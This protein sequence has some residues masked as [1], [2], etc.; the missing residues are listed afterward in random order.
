MNTLSHK[1]VSIAL[2][3]T[4]LVSLSGAILPAVA[5]AQSTSDLQAQ[6]AALLAQI[7]QLQ[8]QLNAQQGGGASSSYNYTRDLTVGSK[9]DDVTALQNLLASKGYF[10]VAATG[11]F[12]PIT[13]AAVAAWQAASGISPAAGYFGPKSRAAVAAMAGPAAPAAPGAPVGVPAPNA[14]A[15]GLVVSLASDNPAPGSLIPSSSRNKVLNVTFTAGV[16]GP[17]TVSEVKFK[18]VGVLSDSSVSGAYLTEAGKVLAQYNSISGGVLNF[19]GLSLAVPAG[20]SRTFGLQI[21]PAAG[22]SAGNTVSFSIESAADVTSWDASNVAVNESGSFPVKGNIFTVTTVSN[23]SLATLTVASSSIGTNVTAGTNNNLIAAWSFTGANSRINLSSLNFKVIGSA[24]K[25]DIKNVKLMVNG[26]QI[27]KT[28]DSVG[29]NGEAF[30]DAS[31]KP[32]VLNTGSNNVQVYADIMGSPS[33]TFQFE[34]LNSYDVFALDSQYN[35]PVLGASNVG[36]QVTIKSGT[37]TMS[38]ATNTPT[39][40]I[41]AGQSS[42]TIAKFTVYAGGEAVKIKWLGVGLNLVS[43]SGTIDRLF[44]NL[45]LVDD[46][47]GQ[48]GTTIN[49]LSTSVTCTDTDFQNST[50]SYRNCFGNSSSPINYTIPANT[51]RVLSLVVDVQS[52]ASFTTVTGITVANTNNLQGLT[53]SATA[54]SAAVNGSALTLS[55]SNLTV[56]ANSA[57]GT[58]NITANSSNKRI[59]SYAFTASSAEGVTVNNVSVTARG[60]MWTNLKVM[61]G[62]TQFG[63]TQGTVSSGTVYSFSG[64]SFTVPAGLTTYVDVYADAI[65]SA[66]GTVAPASVLSGC[67]AS[68]ASS[69]TAISCGSTNGQNIT[70]AGQSTVTVSIDS[71]T[72]ASQQLVMGGSGQSLAIFRFTETSNV[73]DIKIT[74]LSIFDQVTVNLDLNSSTASHVK[75]GFG[76]LSLYNGTALLGSAGSANTSVATATANSTSGPGYYYTFHFATPVVV[77]Q[78]NSVALTLKGDVASYASSGATDNT[79]HT[80]K[81]SVSTDSAID[82]NQEVI[83]ALGNTSNA[84]SAISLAS[85][86][87]A[88]NVMTLLRSKMTVG[89]TM[90]G[91]S[92]GRAKAN[93]DDLATLNFSANSA[94]GV[95]IGSVTMF[96]TGTGPSGTSGGTG[97]GGLSSTFWNTGNTA[98]TC[99]A[100]NCTVQLYDSANGTTYFAVASSTTS[101][102]NLTFDLKNYQLSAGTTKSFSVRLNS[103]NANSFVAAASGIAPTL[104]VTINA[105]G[106]VTWK[107]A[108]DTNAAS[109]LNLEGYVIPVNV[110]SV[111][112]STG[113]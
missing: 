53:S 72:P 90:L 94:G 6:I 88:G 60:N 20:Q 15:S 43:S 47:G 14:P 98:T 25:T 19:S 8:S 55:T 58:Q 56:A 107:D 49:T 1:L 76:N 64:N 104:G 4:T 65:S 3:A 54:S 59:S 18:K 66:S 67:S 2:S 81:I 68:G 82:T 113:S 108:L 79:T 37:I 33:Y 106:N 80:F 110:A 109:A 95:Q 69:L 91:L 21:D 52:T 39:G 85:S 35:I 28:L 99:A 27:G 40:N 62:N 73:E 57:L 10:T 63:T 50:T 45:A 38:Q 46:A 51:T 34:I 32:G 105:I 24:T 77:P 48:V 92:S 112:Y 97:G 86:S 42:V 74:D 30:F 5:H 44:K 23:P 93:V 26:T 36:T 111:S 22:L 71:A 78:A 41:A 103:N 100:A 87:V 61:V 13:K 96:F 11:Y 75:S 29:A 9:G 70:F 16:S 31:D 101:G 89:A 17:V 102:N 12:G 84:T 83:V 7:Q